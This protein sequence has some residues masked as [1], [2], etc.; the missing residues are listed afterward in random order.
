MV[1][2]PFPFLS[3]AETSPSAKVLGAAD[4]GAEYSLEEDE[5]SLLP[6]VKPCC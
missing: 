5:D 4:S 3:T 1:T 6:P 2:F